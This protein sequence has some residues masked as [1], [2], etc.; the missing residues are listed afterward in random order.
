MPCLRNLLVTPLRYPRI[1][2]L[3][4]ELAQHKVSCRTLL[5][6]RGLGNPVNLI[7]GYAFFGAIIAI[8][9]QVIDAM[10]KSG[11]VGGVL[12]VIAQMPLVVVQP[13]TLRADIGRDGDGFC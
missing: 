7:C 2:A 6:G 9:K 8:Y 11:Q 5:F 4:E 12:G 10:F 3:L 13:P 1:A